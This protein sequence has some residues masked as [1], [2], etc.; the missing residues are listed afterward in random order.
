MET[1][2]IIAAISFILIS[3]GT[4]LFFYE[5]KE[6]TSLTGTVTSVKAIK[7][8]PYKTALRT[9]LGAVELHC[10][11]PQTLV[12]KLQTTTGIH[13]VSVPTKKSIQV[14]DEVSVDITRTSTLLETNTKTQLKS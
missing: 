9:G 5:K 4:F 1:Q 13:S 12:L 3:V 10:I 6:T 2:I 14:G 11:Y 8:F 7:S